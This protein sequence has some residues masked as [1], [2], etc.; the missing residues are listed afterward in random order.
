MM[1]LKGACTVRASP[2]SV[3]HDMPI[4]IES[5]PTGIDRPSL[6][7]RSKPMAWTASYSV[8]PSCSYP[9]EHIQLALSL[10]LVI[11]STYAAAILVSVSA[12]AMRAAA[13]PLRIESG[14]RSPLVMASPGAAS[15]NEYDVRVTATSATGT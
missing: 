9:A 12:T 10:T 14:V 8:A 1:G 13:A 6:G 5:L 15:S 3:R 4:D 7:H 11:S 2:A